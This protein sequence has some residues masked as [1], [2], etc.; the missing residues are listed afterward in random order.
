MTS[1]A[2]GYHGSERSHVIPVTKLEDFLYM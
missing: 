2:Y 1:V